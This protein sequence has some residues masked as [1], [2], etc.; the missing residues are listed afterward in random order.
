MRFA[1]AFLLCSTALFAQ[2]KSPLRFEISWPKPRD[3]H[4]VLIISTANGE[5]RNA[6]SEG[7]DTQQI[8]GVDVD[9][10]RTALIDAATLGYPRESLSQIPAGDYTVQAVLNLYETF[11]RSDGRTV[12]LPMDQGEGQ[13][14]SL[15]P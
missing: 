7:L 8:F 13:L 14:W 2:P 9:G 1:A 3:G 11:H 5:P 12:K 15:K 6:V 10:A 4:I